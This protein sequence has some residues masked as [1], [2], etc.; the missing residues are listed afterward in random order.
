MGNIGHTIHRAKTDKQTKTHLL[1][2]CKFSFMVLS[3][4][5]CLNTTNEQIDSCGLNLISTC[6]AKKNQYA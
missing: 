5:S 6:F 2:C 4:R 3:T 1:F